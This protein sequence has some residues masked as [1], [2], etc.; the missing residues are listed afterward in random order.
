[1]P[2]KADN[3]R[4]SGPKA[5]RVRRRTATTA[6]ESTSAELVEEM[7]GAEES[8]PKKR[9]AAHRVTAV[10]D[11]SGPRGRSLLGPVSYTHL[12]LPTIS[13]W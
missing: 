6:A 2:S 10:R 5:K 3:A 1:M 8:A 11:T 13:T 12:T 4:E 7:T 9:A